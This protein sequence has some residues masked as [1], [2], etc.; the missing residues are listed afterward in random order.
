[1]S[2]F[3]WNTVTTGL[4]FIQQLNRLETDIKTLKRFQSVFANLT[5]CKRFSNTYPQQDIDWQ[6]SRLKNS[7]SRGYH[8]LNQ[9]Q[10]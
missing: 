9:D 6:K 4:E 8:G 2:I 10:I 5:C 7:P 3:D 1:M